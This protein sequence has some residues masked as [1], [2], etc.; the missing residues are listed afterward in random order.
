MAVLAN[1]EM[2]RFIDVANVSRNDP[3][4][5]E[6]ASFKRILSIF[7]SLILRHFMSC[8]PISKIVST[9]GQK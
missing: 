4:P 9:P 5:E 2:L 8:P 6:Q 3:H 1:S 7:P